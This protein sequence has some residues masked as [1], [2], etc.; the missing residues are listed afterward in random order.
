MPLKQ[1]KP[2]TPGMRQRK[3]V[4]SK[5]RKNTKMRNIENL[6]EEVILK[7]LKIM[8]KEELSPNK[9]LKYQV[10]LHNLDY[11]LMEISK[12]HSEKNASLTGYK[13]IHHHHA[14]IE[15]F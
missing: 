9:Q 8:L 12:Y 4:E 15:R 14:T 5:N 10:H 2:R 13:P 3:I 6:Q 11:Y 1:Y 7:F